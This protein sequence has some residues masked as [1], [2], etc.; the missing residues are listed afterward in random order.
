MEDK[1]F[2]LLSEANEN[3]KQELQILKF[4]EGKAED[5]VTLLGTIAEFLANLFAPKDAPSEAQNFNV[6][7]YSPYG[8]SDESG[9]GARYSEAIANIDNITSSE[10]AMT[11]E[12]VEVV[13]K[14]G[15]LQSTPGVAG[16]IYSGSGE[17]IS[18]IP[19]D[20]KFIKNGEVLRNNPRDYDLF[21]RLVWA[22][23]GGEGF[24][25]Q[26]AVAN[27][28]LNRDAS[29]LE[30]MPDSIREVIEQKSTKNGVTTYQFSPMGDGRI[31]QDL[32]AAEMNTARTAVYHA[33]THGDIT[34]ELYFWNPKNSE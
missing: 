9:G 28:V 1:E 29:E 24:L 34:E 10:V 12:S 14:S 31:N 19:Y 30:Y 4:M 27:V 8:A 32:T 3:Q 18:Y 6:S 2:A 20:E 17:G 25:G 33:L 7:D 21:A 5:Q 22:E 26:V 13:A 23:A 15:V 11:A 16:S